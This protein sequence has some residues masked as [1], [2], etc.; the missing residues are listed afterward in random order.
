MSRP[1]T[2]VLVSDA[3]PPVGAATDTSVGFFVGE[4]AQ[5]P[6]GET[7]LVRSLDSF[8]EALGDRINPP[9]LYDSVEAFFRDRGSRAYV[10]RLVPPDAKRAT[11]AA[12]TPAFTITATSPG[13]W[14]NELTLSLATTPAVLVAPR[15][16]QLVEEPPPSEPAKR[17][18]GKASTRDD[19]ENG[20]NGEGENGGPEAGMVSVYVAVRRGTTVL[21]RSAS[22]VATVGELTAWSATSNYVRVSGGV[23]A[24]ALTAGTH[25]LD[26]G[27]DGTLP[28]T[29]APLLLDAVLGFDPALGPGQLQAPGKFAAAQ[30]EALLRGAEFGNRV[31]YLD[32]DPALDEAGLTAHVN[33]LRT[34]EVDRFG[35]L[36]APRAVVPGRA[37]GTFRTIPW[38]GVQAGLTAFRDGFGNPAQ[39]AAGSFGISRWAVDL[40]R[41]YSDDER[42]RLMHA[43]VNTAR[44]VQ[45][46]VR[47]YG[48]RSLV[49]ENGPRRAWLQ[50]SG[51]RVAMAIKSE[52]DEIAERYVF[53]VLD[54]RKRK[55]A[56]F[57]GELGGL[58]LRYFTGDALY[59]ETA[60]DAFRVETG[61]A[62]NTPESIAD[63]QLRAILLLKVSPFAE[64]VEVQI[65]KQAITEALA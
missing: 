31:A 21:E 57:G 41:E 1:G 44:I 3:L 56:E 24:T 48:F 4:A 8:V 52:A 7:V 55:I 63:G 6:E 65:V 49:D 15:R 22:T 28:V 14:G 29:S 27:E 38:S 25:N 20:E 51:V 53:A 45:S 47:A 58:C 35:G 5:G 33:T 60:E 18:R 19:G 13:E 34:L 43:G 39:P 16:L 42:E 17:T 26:G 32:A 11:A 30:H 9:G 46:S 40:E 50:L 12:T 54:G 36:F 61:D 10:R 62:V 59:G 2:N 64:F 37:P 23:A